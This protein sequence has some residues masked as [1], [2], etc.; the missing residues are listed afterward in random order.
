MAANNLNEA[1]TAAEAWQQEPDDFDATE[2]LC[3][4]LDYA[5]AA[6]DRIATLETRIATL[7]EA[8]HH[9]AD[10]ETHSGGRWRMARDVLGLPLRPGDRVGSMGAR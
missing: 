7:E 4:L 3:D 10:D 1:I 6:R 8:L 2:E 5:R 9:F